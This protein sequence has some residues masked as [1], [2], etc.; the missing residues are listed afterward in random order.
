MARLA[1]DRTPLTV[2]PLSNQKLCVFP[3]LKNH[4]IG[5]LLDAGLCV[6]INSD[7][8]AYFG[9]YMNENFLQTFE[10]TGLTAQQAYVL[11]QNSFEASFATEQQKN[12]WLHALKQAFQK[13][14]EQ[15]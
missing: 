12:Q 9:G 1:K 8:P 7:D 14:S 13:F 4:N 15:D 10:A 5:Q 11:A 3:D 6:T 2:C